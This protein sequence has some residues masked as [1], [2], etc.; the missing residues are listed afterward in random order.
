MDCDEG[1]EHLRV[2]KILLNTIE[3]LMLLFDDEELGKTIHSLSPKHST[4]STRSG[5]ANTNPTS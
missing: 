3:G 2:R 4:I 1:D 5:N